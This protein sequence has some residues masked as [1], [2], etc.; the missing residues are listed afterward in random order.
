[1]RE[2][3]GTVW[4]EDLRELVKVISSL[5]DAG[6]DGVEV[7]LDYPLVHGGLLESKLEEFLRGVVDA[8]LKLAIHAP[9]RDLNISS[10]VREVSIT[11]LKL[12]SEALERALKLAEVEYVVIHLTTN[13]KYCGFRDKE[14]IKA[15][16]EN[17]EV[18]ERLVREL[19]PAPLLIET[20][21]GRCCSGEEQLPLILSSR[22]TIGVCLDPTHILERR[23]KKYKS[24]YRLRDIL[25]DLPPII[26]ERTEVLHIH[27]YRV[28]EGVFVPHT[29]PT[30]EQ[31]TEFREFARFLKSPSKPVVLEIFRSDEGRIVPPEGLKPLVE[32]IRRW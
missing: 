19:S 6:F 27:G 26:L 9:W 14:C 30:E 10:P 5:Q 7:S 25:R 29:Y 3:F 31:L 11:S 21:S 24:V 15:S 22:S 28:K 2:V 23:L 13:Q 8:G 17:L 4:Y 18:L 20:T 1:M 12:I 32:E 16:I